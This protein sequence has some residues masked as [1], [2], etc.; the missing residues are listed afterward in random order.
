[1]SQNILIVDDEADIRKL[2]RGILEDEGYQIAE[3]ADA[4]SAYKT[5]SEKCPDL[6]ILD[7]WLQGSDQD[8]LEILEDIKAKNPLLPVLMISGHGTI[9]TA[10]SSIQKGAYDFI[11]KPFKADRLI[12][13]IKRALEAAA[14]KRENETLKKS[15]EG[16]VV[17]II[18]SGTES[19][20]LRQMLMKVAPTNSRVLL[21]GEAGSGKNIAARFIHQNSNRAD[22]PFM[23]LSCASLSPDR[24]EVVLF[25]SALADHGSQ[26]GIL[27]QANGGTLLLD[28]VSD[29]PYETQAKILRVLQEE[30]FQKIGSQEKQPIDVRILASTNK[31]LQEEIAKGRFREDLYYR[32][33]VVTIQMPSL[34]TRLKD[35]PALVDYFLQEFSQRTGHPIKPFS[36][37]ALAQMKRYKWPGNIRQLSNVVE[38]VCIM[39]NGTAGSYFTAEDLPSEISGSGVSAN[40]SADAPLSSVH[41]AMVAT[42]PLREAREQFEKD[43]LRMQIERFDGNISKTAEF[44]GMERSALHRKIKAL[45]LV[46]DDAPDIAEKHQ[47]RA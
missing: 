7:I 2:I 6:V 37:D 8:G 13:M 19:D 16:Q 43:Y 5:I 15:Y 32:L 33:N 46:A 36:E 30:R 28:E 40:G 24:L 26:D 38:W 44:I 3:A 27:Q 20:N 35:L 34:R 31:D 29:M 22:K 25:G 12:L 41:A 17:Q 21:L 4:K 9:E 14:L 10:V 45:Q 47:K 1:M 23:I 39:R 42:L 11:E 18:G